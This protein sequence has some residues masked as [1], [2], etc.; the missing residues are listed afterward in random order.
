MYKNKRGSEK[1]GVKPHFEPQMS[2]S[3]LKYLDLSLP[4]VIKYMALTQNPEGI[5]QA[6]ANGMP[7]TTI[8]REGGPPSK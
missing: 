4:W 7:K 2:T 8:T 6:I 3:S 1:R 5:P